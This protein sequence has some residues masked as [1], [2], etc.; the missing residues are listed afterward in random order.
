MT[1]FQDQKL[2]D[3]LRIEGIDSD[4]AFA[5]ANKSVQPG[6]CMNVDCNYTCDVEPDQEEGWCDSCNDNSVVSLQNLLLF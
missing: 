3:L 2:T 1:K 6:I 4:A 5:I